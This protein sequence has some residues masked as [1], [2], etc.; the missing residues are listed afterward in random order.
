MWLAVNRGAAYQGNTVD[1]IVLGKQ[2]FTSIEIL[3]Y[4][5]CEIL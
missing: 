2:K 4:N 3:F 1:M 5:V